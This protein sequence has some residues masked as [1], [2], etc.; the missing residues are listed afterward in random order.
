MPRIYISHRP[1][2]SS[3]NEVAIIRDRLI[4]EFGEENILQST[5]SNMEITTNLQRL[6]QSCDVLLVVIGRYWT[7]MVDEQGNY[8]LED[9]YDP[10]HVEVDAGLKT[11]MVIK[12]LVVDGSR[13]PSIDSLPDAL[14]NLM[15]KDVI[16]AQDDMLL[17]RELDE[18][19]P[20]LEVIP[21]GTMAEEND[22]D[23]DSLDVPVYIK[24]SKT[25]G[26]ASSTEL[27]R[28]TSE[29]SRL[30]EYKTS[31]TTMNFV[32]IIG[33]VIFIGLF[34][35]Y[36]SIVESIENSS[37]SFPL[38]ATPRVIT[39]EPITASN[40]R[41]LR[42]LGRLED[43]IR[44]HQMSD[45]NS[46]FIYIPGHVEQKCIYDMRKYRRA[47]CERVGNLS[48]STLDSDLWDAERDVWLLMDNWDNEV[49]IYD[50]QSNVWSMISYLN[51]KVSIYSKP[52]DLYKIYE[53]TSH[54]LAIT[55]VY[56]HVIVATNVGELHWISYMT[57]Y[58]VDITSFAETDTPLE[59]AELM[60]DP[61]QT[62]LLVQFGNQIQLWD[63]LRR[64]K[65]E[66]I[67]LDDNI[68]YMEYVSLF[69]EPQILVVTEDGMIYYLSS[70]TLEV[71]QESSFLKIAAN[72]DL[73]LQVTDISATG[74]LAVRTR[75]SVLQL[76]NLYTEELIFEETFSISTEHAKFN[77]DGSVIALVIPSKAMFL[78][79]DS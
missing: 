46:D 8:L 64:E 61:E 79:I 21:T 30:P 45:S 63:V 55:N 22:I 14:K 31:N 34:L 2:D 53:L 41:S 33:G 71:M 73:P 62:V 25:V 6:V 70:D 7:N 58:E 12:T 67:I 26:R 16:E 72:P 65:Q 51:D 66:S 36:L 74:L 29:P 78:G 10:I 4:A 47:R 27:V 56:N 40:I 15:L 35:A 19:I 9:P 1:E 52:S 57:N 54:P 5:G 76:W 20:E 68:Q 39:N 59:Q 49:T 13:V 37:Y 18:M 28:Q 42:I 3:R 17:G 11:M 44:F 60:F 50:E 69:D 23:I 43:G 24:Q 77:K 75:A 48:S 32:L 38:T